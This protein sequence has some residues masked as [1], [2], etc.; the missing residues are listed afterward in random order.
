M[1]RWM[2]FWNSRVNAVSASIIVP[3]VFGE[4]LHEAS[5]LCTYKS[6]VSTHDGLPLDMFMLQNHTSPYDTHHNPQWCIHKLKSSYHDRSVSFVL[7][8]FLNDLHR[9]DMLL[10]N[11][12]VNSIMQHFISKYWLFHLVPVFVIVYFY[13]LFFKFLLKFS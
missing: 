1:R 6:A 8:T 13:T 5:G 11:L 10:Q 7:P 12:S 4:D 9:E 2:S 3:K